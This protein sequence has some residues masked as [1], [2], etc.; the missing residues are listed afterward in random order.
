MLTHRPFALFSIILIATFAFLTATFCSAA[1]SEQVLHSFGALGDGYYPY[2]GLAIDASGNLYGSTF[3]GGSGNLGTVFQ[4]VPGSGGTWT[5]HILYNFCS[6]SGCTDG[7]SPQ[8]SLLVDASGTLYGTTMSGGLYGSG[9]VFELVLGP[10]GKWNERVLHS[11]NTI[12]IG[13]YYPLA[14]VI[15]DASGNLYGTT[16]WGGAYNSGTVFRLSPGANH[17]W[18]K[19]ILRSFNDNGHDGYSP[20]ASLIFDKNGNL[21]GTTNLG[22]SSGKGCGGQGCGTV[23]ELTPGSGGKWTETILHNFKDNG[24][25]GFKPWG[26]VVFDGSGNLYGTTNAGGPTTEG[27]GNGGC[28]VAFELIPLGNGQWEEKILHNFK[29]NNIDG[30]G[31]TAG[32]VLDKNGRLYGT[33]FYG[34]AYN[35]GAV[36]ELSLSNNRWTESVVHN[37]DWTIDVHDGTNPLD[38]LISDKNGNLYVTTETGGNYNQGAVI[39]ITP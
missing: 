29:D 39:E 34:G 25:D 10:H 3:D 6:V 16:Q 17:K 2:A 1:V 8:G 15:S 33:T 31:S 7:A 36:F 30:Y 35:D 22:G 5:E 13:G 18:T 14:G 20:Y 38:G 9:T 26:S 32:L 24:R 21:Y 28:G 37:F 11:F 23:F 19:T 4:L 27:C 12:G